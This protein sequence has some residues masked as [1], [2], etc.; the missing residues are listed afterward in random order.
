M[1]PEFKYFLKYSSDVCP[2]VLPLILTWKQGVSYGTV[3]W[4]ETKKKKI[5]EPM[6]W[7]KYPLLYCG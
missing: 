5:G 3:Q 4:A 6:D 2:I 1:C 7:V